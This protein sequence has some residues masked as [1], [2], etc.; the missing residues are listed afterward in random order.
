MSTMS[1]ETMDHRHTATATATA[2]SDPT[3]DPTGDGNSNSNASSQTVTASRTT[4][5]SKVMS[6]VSERDFISSVLSNDDVSESMDETII[7]CYDGCEPTKS[8]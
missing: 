1:D 7:V 5:P 6:D 4:S 2:S 8:S 3:G